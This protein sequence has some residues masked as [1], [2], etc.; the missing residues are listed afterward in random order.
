MS[1][2]ELWGT[3]KA[4]A[5]FVG[6]QHLEALEQHDVGLVRSAHISMCGRAWGMWIVEPKCVLW[7]L[8][9]EKKTKLATFVQE[10]C[11]YLETMTSSP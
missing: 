1:V 10:L 11:C 7:V 9:S 5:Q 4:G 6:F 3:T 2:S 8:S